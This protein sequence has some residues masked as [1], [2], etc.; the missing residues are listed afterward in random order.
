MIDPIT[1]RDELVAAG[2]PS[3][4]IATCRDGGTLSAIAWAD[5]HPTQAEQNTAAAV[6]AAHDPTKREREERTA[7]QHLRN[8]AQ[9]I[10]DGTATNAEVRDALAKVIRRLV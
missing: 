6:L 1:L 5:G 9:R 8:L 2:I 10:E 3:S 7:Q 4:A